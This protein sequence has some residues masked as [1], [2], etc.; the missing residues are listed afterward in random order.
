M[1]ATPFDQSDYQVRFE[2]GRAGLARLAPSDVVI[3]V[4]VL[5][6]ST[7]ITRALEEGAEV[8]ALL[9]AQQPV[10]PNGAAVARLAQDGGSA[11]VLLGCLRNASAVA[12]A[13]LGLQ[14]AWGR[15]TSVAVIAAGEVVPGEVVPGAPGAGA[16]PVAGAG[17]VPVAG[18]GEVRFAV[19][20]LLG[21]GA[22]IAA[23]SD[24]GTDHTSPEAAAAC[25]AF[26]GLRR[27]TGHLLSASGSGRE[28]L[29]RQHGAQVAAAAEVDVTSVV[30]RWTGAGW[31]G[32]GE[33]FPAGTV[34]RS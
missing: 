9:P 14:Q 30:P 10:S 13:C 16:E 34:S 33:N 31:V 22:V 21:A 17:G 20:D 23:L 7:T 27:A 6:Y 19:E 32:H 2:W 28:L 29:A 3:V 1:H 5:R 4:D 11:E 8:V 26:L 15:R 12:R 25:E 18:A 24:L